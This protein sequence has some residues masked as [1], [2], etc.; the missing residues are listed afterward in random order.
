MF[1]VNDVVVYAA[2]GVCEIV[3]TEDQRFG[4]KSESYFVLKPKIDKAQPFMCLQTTRRRWQKCEKSCQE[5]VS[6]T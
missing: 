5:K 6:T 2:H 1:K 4:E 3:G